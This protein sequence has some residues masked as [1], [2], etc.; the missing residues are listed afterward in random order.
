MCAFGTDGE[1][2]LADAFSHEFTL[3]VRLTCF[4]HKRRNTEQK[5]KDLRFSTVSATDFGYFWKM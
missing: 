1:E 4:I 2:A 3:A 5:L